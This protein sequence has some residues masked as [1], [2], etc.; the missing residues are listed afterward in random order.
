MILYFGICFLTL[1]YELRAL[2][3]QTLSA[4]FTCRGPSRASAPSMVTKTQTEIAV[5]SSLP[6][7][8]GKKCYL[9]DEKLLSNEYKVRRVDLIAGG[10]FLT[11]TP[12]QRVGGR[13]VQGVSFAS[14]MWP[15]LHPGSDHS[16]P[17]LATVLAKS[18]S[19]VGLLPAL[20]PC[21][22]LP[23]QPTLTAATRVTL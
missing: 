9:A 14:V 23:K 10:R 11:H 13:A 18:L 19:W 21:F 4:L 2:C 8:T 5:A 1:F 6:Q 15:R 22:C 7:G 16:S 12:G 20:F 3:G 17:P